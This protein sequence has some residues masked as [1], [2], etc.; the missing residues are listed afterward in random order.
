MKMGSALR[1]RVEG[2]AKSIHSFNG[3]GA[4]EMTVYAQVPMSAM[5]KF[6]F[7]GAHDPSSESVTFICV[8]MEG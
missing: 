6:H 7:H 2:D 8:W 3:A 1:V 5:R 4:D